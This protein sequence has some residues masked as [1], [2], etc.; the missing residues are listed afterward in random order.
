MTA[1]D[2]AARFTPAPIEE[3]ERR[4]VL[5]AARAPEAAAARADL[6][7]AFPILTRIGVVDGLYQGLYG[8]ITLRVPGA[9]DYFWV[10]SLAR[11]FNDTREEDLILLGS[12][13]QIVEGE[14]RAVNFAAFYI[15]SA[16][17]KARPEVSCVAHT[18]P[19]AGCAFAALG[20][21]LLPIDQV[22]CVFFED[23]AVH[24]DYSGVIAGEPQG[25]AIVRSL[26]SRRALILMNHGLITCGP[27]VAHAVID[28]YELER[29][30]DVQLRALATGR[31]PKLIPPEAARQVRAIR[32][33]PRR[34]RHEW[35][36]LRRE[37]A[38]RP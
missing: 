10:N 8:H 9:P 13:G 35:S 22:G 36:V 18:H 23:H 1:K 38:G 25:E 24:S 30:C 14:A 7:A 11:R 17:H 6:A 33:D 2:A 31:E 4:R 28:M 27:D 19:A 37:L 12:G 16:I 26:G 15:H 20:T 32:T 5:D 21:P 34:Y 29:T 3:D